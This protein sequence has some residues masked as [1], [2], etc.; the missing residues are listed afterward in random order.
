MEHQNTAK[1][2]GK[3]WSLLKCLLASYV[4]TALLLLAL[5]GAL[6]KLGLG[7]QFVRGAVIAIYVI[8]TLAGGYLAGKS[9][10]TRKFLWGLLVG[11]AYFIVLA[12]MSL[13]VNGEMSA[14]GDSFFTTLVLCA[15]GG[16]LGGMLGN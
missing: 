6:W 13:A 12:V 14:L 3:V 1:S 10:Q 9:M 16:M 11:I 5:A 2:G 8:A 15:G 7:E 4:L